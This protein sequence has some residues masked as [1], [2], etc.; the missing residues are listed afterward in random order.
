MDRS[1]VRALVALSVLALVGLAL[2]GPVSPASAHTRPMPLVDEPPAT[3]AA[4][5]VIATPVEPPAPATIWLA[6]VLT[7]FL[8]VA[9]AAPRRALVVTLALVLVLLALET[10]V[11]SVHHLSDLQAASQCAVAS[12]STHVQGTEQPVAP[13][14]VW[15]ATP[16][17]AVTTPDFDRPGSRPLRPDEGRAPPAA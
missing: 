11:H 8:G 10:G 14:G 4:V 7:V 13:D 3:V 16:I 17:G 1:R 2:V 6:L 12:A 15:V 5:A 9:V